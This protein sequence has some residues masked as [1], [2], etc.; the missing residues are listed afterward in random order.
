MQGEATHIRSIR[1]CS[2]GV[3]FIGSSLM[4]NE[5]LPPINQRCAAV[6]VCM[7][8]A[9]RVPATRFSF[10]GISAAMRWQNEAAVAV[11][12]AD[13]ARAAVTAHNASH[14]TCS[15]CPRS[16]HNQPSATLAGLHVNGC[17]WATAAGPLSHP[18]SC[19]SAFRQVGPIVSIGTAV[20]GGLR[21][22]KFLLNVPQS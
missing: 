14:I 18:R 6:I 21:T 15:P 13:V 7:S 20:R 5:V 2:S 16:D 3:S 11:G 10:I 17:N 1:C 4:L 8:N 12:V 19:R 9:R 22:G